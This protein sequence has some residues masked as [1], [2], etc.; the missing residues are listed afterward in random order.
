MNNRMGHLMNKLMLS[1]E[2]AT[3]LMSIKSFRMLS[4]KERIKLRM[5]LWAC[6]YCRRF[7]VQNEIIDEGI[8][9]LLHPEHNHLHCL[10]EEKKRPTTRG[11]QSVN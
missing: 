2:D 9:D 10:S 5:H 11:N 8:K 1:C 6:I 4:M 3:S 7:N